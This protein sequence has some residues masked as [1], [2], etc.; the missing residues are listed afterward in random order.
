MLEIENKYRATDWD[1][2]QAQLRQLGAT[3]DAPRQESDSYYNAPDRD[4]ARTDEVLRIRRIG[5]KQY[6]TYKGPKLDRQVKART[7]LEVPLADLNDVSAPGPG[8]EALL[9]HLG[10]RPVAVVQ[11][12]RTIYHLTCGG[13]AFEICLDDVE[14]L[15]RYVEI[16]TLAS[17]AELDAARAGVLA[18]AAELGLNQIEPHSYLR[19]CLARASVNPS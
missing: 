6:L 1:Q 9:Q 3:A 7:E 2:L 10:Y 17:E 4:F 15:G 13:R 19:L 5:S 11:K 8:I 12:E 18:L 14:Q 16:E